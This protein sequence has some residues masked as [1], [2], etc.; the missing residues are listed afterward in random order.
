MI[1]KLPYFGRPCCIPQPMAIKVKNPLLLSA[2]VGQ[3]KYRYFVQGTIIDTIQSV[4]IREYIVDIPDS[5][6]V[7]DTPQLYVKDFDKWSTDSVI[8]DYINDHY[9]T[10][11]LVVVNTDPTLSGN[12]TVTDPLSVNVDVIDGRH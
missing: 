7:P 5:Q 4:N 1:V 11:G 9:V 10:Q 2:N 8:I 6:F 12:G 3:T